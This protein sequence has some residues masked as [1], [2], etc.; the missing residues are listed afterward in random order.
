MEKS[1]ALELKGISKYF[2]TVVANKDVSLTVLKGEILAILGENG[3]GKTTLMNMIAGIYY[4][5]EG[6]IVIDGKE[7]VIRSPHDAFRYKIGMV[8][9]HFKLVDV[10]TAAQNIILGV[11]DGKKFKIKEVNARVQEIADKYGFIIDPKKKI[12]RTDGGSIYAKKII[13]A[14]H[15]PMIN[16]HGGYFMKLRQSM[17]YTIAVSGKGAEDMYLDE[18]EDGLSVRP[19][20][21]G[22]LLGGGDHRTGRIDD[23]RHFAALESSADKLFGR[24]NVTHRWCAEDV[25]TFDGMPMAGKYS[26]SLEGIYVVTGFNKWGMTNAMVCASVLT[27][28][29]LG[30]ENPYAE[31]FSPQRH[32]KKSFGDFVSNA[33]TNVGGI[34]LGYCRI[35]LKTAKDVPAG[36]GMIVFHHGKKRAV[37]RDLSGEL[38]VIGNKCPHMHCELKWNGETNTWD[39]PCHGSRFDIY[40]NVISE[41]STKSCKYRREDPEN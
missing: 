17:S 29:L 5:D 24:K 9:Q 36:S 38:H 11:D 33:L 3:S 14:T 2:G 19:Y 31:I 30:K 22:T 26:K 12:L 28:L 1:V 20:A 23:K 32:I 37:Y 15:Y 10:F 8:H 16:S 21:E 39:C 13:V 6:T 18:R 27:D 4:P 25:M 7:T 34:F 35:T 40:G 41:P